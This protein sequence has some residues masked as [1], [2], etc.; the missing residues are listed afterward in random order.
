MP[1]EPTTP[2]QVQ[3]RLQVVTQQIAE[4]ITIGTAIQDAASKNDAMAVI[5]AF[6][7]STKQ[8]RKIADA[9]LDYAETVEDMLG[10]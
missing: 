8:S 2:E 6:I 10:L 4:F 3:E 5:R 1:N 7:A 9:L